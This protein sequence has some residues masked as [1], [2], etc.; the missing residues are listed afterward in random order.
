MR[1]TSGQSLLG[2][3]LERRRQVGEVGPV[4][5][6]E[7]PAHDQDVLDVSGGLQVGQ[8]R[9]HAPP[10]KPENRRNDVVYLS[11]QSLAFFLVFFRGL[12]LRAS[13]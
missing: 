9:L 12:S 13:L 10:D 3:L 7:G 5:G 4:V 6:L 2:D 8:R 11:K 1:G